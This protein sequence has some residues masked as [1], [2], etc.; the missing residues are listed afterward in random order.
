MHDFWEFLEDGRISDACL[1]EG[2]E[3]TGPVLRGHL[4]KN[5]AV[6]HE[7]LEQRLPPEFKRTEISYGATLCARTASPAPWCLIVHDAAYPAAPRALAAAI[8][9]QLAGVP[10]IWS[11]A[12]REKNKPFAVPPAPLLAAW[13]LAGIENAA[14]LES[15]AFLARWREFMASS[16][17]AASGPGRV[18]ILGAPAWSRKIHAACDIESKALLR[19]E[20]PAPRI[21]LTGDQAGA[22]HN[23]IS[24]LH[25]DAALQ[26]TEKN[27]GMPQNANQGYTAVFASEPSSS[28]A[29]ALALHLDYAHCGCWVWPELDAAFFLNHNFF[30]CN[31]L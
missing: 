13:E 21:L 19:R 17:C 8:P 3:Q 10:L 20:G 14:V 12:L 16:D 7:M 6:H 28:Y 24:A 2:Y 27:E 22:Y 31:K 5:I 1:A 26:V 25:P 18:L 11:I 4:K 29:H 9:A 30:L 15:D 23:V